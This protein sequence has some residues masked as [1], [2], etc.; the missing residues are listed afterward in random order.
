MT[1]FF[2]ANLLQTQCLAPK[3]TNFGCCY[4]GELTDL[5]FDPET[6]SAFSNSGSVKPFSVPK[7]DPWPAN[8]DVS[9]LAIFHGYLFWRC[10]A[11]LICRSALGGAEHVHP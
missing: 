6:E 1:T 10:L 3:S 2:A 9:W 4:K 8:Q 11:V 5:G 7:S